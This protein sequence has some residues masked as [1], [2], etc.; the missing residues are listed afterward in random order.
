MRVSFKAIA[1]AGLVGLGW[2]AVG[3]SDSDSGGAGT[4]DQF[5]AQVCDEY[6]DC[7]VAAGRPGDGA[8]CRAFYGAF[9]PPNY[10]QAA[11]DACLA[12]I[13]ALGADKC[14]FSLDTPSCDKVFS[15]GGTAQ[16]GD[17]C[18]DDADCA[19]SGEGD[20]E[21]VSDFSVDSTIQQCQVRA[22]GVAGSTPCVG[23][24]DGNVTFSSGSDDGIPTMGYLCHI[25]D[26]LTCDSTSGACQPLGAVGEP[27][28]GFDGCVPSAYCDFASNSC[29]ARKAL[30]EPCA[31]DDECQAGG[32]CDPG[33]ATESTCLASRAQG[34]AC[35]SNSECASDNCTNQKCG[36]NDDLALAFLCGGG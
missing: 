16:P 15:E 10:D 28:V 33:A 4:K 12:E 1:V 14:D 7:C 9:A 20:V 18:E 27:C 32:Y 2:A 30:G 13:R 22:T 8:Q 5:L 29:L 36:A 24:V 25:A 6:A 21:C 17:P 11:A 34:E 19:P 31:G 23:T 35:T 3:C 26:G